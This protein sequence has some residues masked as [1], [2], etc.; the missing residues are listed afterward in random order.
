MVGSKSHLEKS[1]EM[2]ENVRRIATEII[3][4]GRVEYSKQDVKDQVM[5]GQIIQKILDI[6]T[7]FGK[8]MSK[9][10]GNRDKLRELQEILR[11][12]KKAVD[13]MKAALPELRKMEFGT[14]VK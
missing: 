10:M 2:K 3:A 1:E 13:Q 6:E 8:M 9:G 12:V 11:P 4:R 7:Y 14:R 5:R